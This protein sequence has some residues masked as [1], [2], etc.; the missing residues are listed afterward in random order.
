MRH[1]QKD[2]FFRIC[3]NYFNFSHGV[4]LCQ[5]IPTNLRAN[6]NLIL[7]KLSSFSQKNK[8]SEGPFHPNLPNFCLDVTEFWCWT[9]CV[10]T[11]ILCFL[12]IFAAALLRNFDPELWNK[13]VINYLALLSFFFSKKCEKVFKKSQ[14]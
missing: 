10:R 6:I 14:K 13:L 2:F 3:N 5:H 9:F 4:W 1:F 11:I 12:K 8:K 7:T